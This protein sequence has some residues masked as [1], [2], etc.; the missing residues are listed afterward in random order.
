MTAI[1]VASVVI[2]IAAL[3]PGMFLRLPANVNNSISIC[4]ANA[5]LF[6]VGLS[7]A[8]GVR[9][10]GTVALFV[11]CRYQFGL[12]ETA[13][14][15]H[16]CGWY[17]ALTSLEIFFLAHGAL[18]IDSVVQTGKTDSSA[19]S[20]SEKGSDPL[21]R[22]RK[23]DEINSPPKGQTP[24]RMGSKSKPF[25]HAAEPFRFSQKPLTDST[26]G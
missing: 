8:M 23:H 19:K 10:A 22:G 26:I 21:R 4:R 2:S 14:A 9:F 17:A 1:A 3:L 20:L 5:E 25:S 6:L 15:L 18:A 16:V 11:A 12:T 13:I 7:V 24:F